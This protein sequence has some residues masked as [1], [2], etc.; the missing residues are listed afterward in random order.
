[1]GS[2][3][4]WEAHRQAD[5]LPPWETELGDAHHGIHARVDRLVHRGEEH[6]GREVPALRRESPPPRHDW[7]RQVSQFR[8]RG[9]SGQLCDA[10]ECGVHGLDRAAQR[11]RSASAIVLWISI[12]SRWFSAR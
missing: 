9:R 6:R 11:R 5:V 3:A 1:M 10:Q 4:D 8:E 2:R 12:Q 7:P